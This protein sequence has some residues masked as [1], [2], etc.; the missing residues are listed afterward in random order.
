MKA[1]FPSPCVIRM[2]GELN[3]S[4]WEICCRA[5]TIPRW[6]RPTWK[7]LPKGEFSALA[8][9]L[10]SELMPEYPPASDV[11]IGEVYSP[12]RSWQDA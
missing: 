7:N 6:S 3:L 5:T 12:R 10:A 11:G 8:Q 2:T 4:F 1:K 9:I